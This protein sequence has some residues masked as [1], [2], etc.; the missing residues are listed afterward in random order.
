MKSSD[1]NIKKIK[2]SFLN[3][4]N[5]PARKIGLVAAAV[6]LCLCVI[7][8]LALIN[9]LPFSKTQ[10]SAYRDTLAR[11]DAMTVRGKIAGDGVYA[12]IEH[13][14]DIILSG[15]TDGDIDTAGAYKILS[16]I[17]GR[18][19]GSAAGDLPRL[20]EGRH[21]EESAD[22]YTF[23]YGGMTEEA[24]PVFAAS[25]TGYF[26][27]DDNMDTLWRTAAAHYE[28]NFPPGDV[29]TLPVYL[30]DDSSNS[31]PQIVDPLRDA[32]VNIA[33]YKNTG[34]LTGFDGEI[35][36]YRGAPA[37]IVGRARHVGFEY[38]TADPAIFDLVFG[39]SH[40][41]GEESHE[42]PFSMA[43]N[44]KGGLDVL[45]NVNPGILIPVSWSAAFADAERASR[46]I[47]FAITPKN[48]IPIPEN[49]FDLSPYETAYTGYGEVVDAY[50]LDLVCNYSQYGDE[51][52]AVLNS[53]ILPGVK[54]EAANGLNARIVSDFLSR[55]GI[56]LPYLAAGD[57]AVSPVSINCDYLYTAENGIGSIVIKTSCYNYVTGQTQTDCVFYYFNETD[58]TAAT[59]DDYLAAI[60]TDTAA[61]AA[62]LN[63]PRA[64]LANTGI[65][66]D[67]IQA[68][69]I[70]GVFRRRIHN[71]LSV[72]VR[73]EQKQ[74]IF[75]T[76]TGQ[77]NGRDRYLLFDDTKPLRSDNLSAYILIGGDN[78]Y[79]IECA[80]RLPDMLW[81]SEDRPAMTQR[82]S[83]TACSIAAADLTDG[84]TV[85]FILTSDDIASKYGIDAVEYYPLEFNIL[86]FSL[87]PDGEALICR[88]YII[89]EKGNPD[90]SKNLSEN[91]D[92]Q[93]A[94]AQQVY[95]E[96]CEGYVRADLLTGELVFIDAPQ[97]EPPTEY[98][99]V[100]IY[101]VA[102]AENGFAADTEITETDKAALTL[103]VP[104]TW[105]TEDGFIFSDS[106]R[107]EEKGYLYN[108]RF[109]GG[110]HLIRVGADFVW[111]AD[112]NLRAARQYGDNFEHSFGYG[113]GTVSTSA[114]G[115]TVVVYPGVYYIRVSDQFALFIRMYVYRDD[116][117]G[118]AD[119]P[120]N[121][122]DSLVF[123]YTE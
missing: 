97:T 85:E 61:V 106:T 101:P 88:Y 115:Y 9:L 82:L 78:K 36:Y 74:Y 119:V 68:D 26:A 15:E 90:M 51:Y 118:Y 12:L 56:Y 19:D 84:T 69:E 73:G 109:E 117:D 60:G 72:V 18:L 1:N 93:P 63:D 75:E 103:N 123:T 111:D 121:I 37:G 71:A 13:M 49:T 83:R 102:I 35:L 120:K 44:E 48:R 21:E 107:T 70:I 8:G 32:S 4:F 76:Q 20:F 104:A 5:T 27:Y 55:C 65:P 6:M 41:A 114:G 3:T 47:S 59:L 58:K 99:E 40:A 66:A 87:S 22:L 46:L 112:V 50:I 53:I 45:Y 31:E 17:C 62:R 110:Y 33:E 96:Y 54:G 30:W 52:T 77:E 7:G 81:I 108:K 34:D 64:R 94:I 113:K 57:T 23:M 38:N 39:G 86:Y 98:K 28:K 89:F 95:R 16:A 80:G 122:I 29:F 25:V 116:A 24:A 92:G 91:A 2:N 42:Y 100:T 10:S 105:A 79:T 43:M 14:S 11:V 67:G